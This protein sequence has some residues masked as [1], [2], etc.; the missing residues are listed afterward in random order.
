MMN[1][2]I[3]MMLKRRLRPNREMKTY[4][5]DLSHWS[6]DLLESS[7][8]FTENQKKNIQNYNFV[9]LRKQIFPFII[10]NFCRI[11]LATYT[12]KTKCKSFLNKKNVDFWI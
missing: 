7:N 5:T 2:V 1:K 6:Q 9:N 4:K 12:T 11:E 10:K 8:G 3:K